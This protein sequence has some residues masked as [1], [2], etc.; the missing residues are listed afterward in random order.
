MRESVH[1]ALD[2]NVKSHHEINRWCTE[3][4]QEMINQKKTP[5]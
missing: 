4:L 3:A 1:E 5:I 2:T